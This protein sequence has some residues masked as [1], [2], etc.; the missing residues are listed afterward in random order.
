[1]ITVRSQN[2]VT[3][4]FCWADWC[5][6]SLLCCCFRSLSLVCFYATLPSNLLWFY[7]AVH[8]MKFGDVRLW[9]LGHL[10][11]SWGTVVQ[12]SRFYARGCQTFRYLG[13]SAKK[14][15]S[16]GS[17][18]EDPRPLRS[19]YLEQFVCIMFSLKLVAELSWVVFMCEMGV[20]MV[21]VR[22]WKLFLKS[23]IHH[24]VGVNG[25][26]LCTTVSRNTTFSTF[27]ANFYNV[28]PLSVVTERNTR[29]HIH[30]EERVNSVWEEL[31][32]Q[33]MYI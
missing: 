28:M 12:Q 17:F 11:A 21:W 10:A 9:M 15:I 4:V 13:F 8:S 18:G 25:L 24:L 33:V 16:P 30:S 19:T 31:H 20:D 2:G 23:Q 26:D 7:W 27:S 5:K 6:V 1:M 32:D 14:G 3:Q 22:V 29:H